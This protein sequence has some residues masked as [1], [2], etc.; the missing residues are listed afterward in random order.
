MKIYL[1]G[2]GTGNLNHLTLEAVKTLNNVDLILIP[3][4]SSDTIDLLNIRL[5][6]CKTLITHSKYNITEFQI[7]IRDNKKEYSLSVKQWH[8]EIAATWKKTIVSYKGKK[9]KVGLLIWGDPSLYDSS[10][11]IAEKIIDTHNITVIPGITSIQALMAAHK[12]NMNKIGK[13]FFVTTG[14]FLK[15][16]GLFFDKDRSFVMLD[17]NCSFQYINTEI[18]YMWW[19]AY[20]GMKKEIIYKGY[21][22]EIY[23]KVISKSKMA[24]LKYGWIMD[25]Y[26]LQKKIN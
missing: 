19:G 5:E 24:K 11:K 6:I 7:P 2:I 8:T 21:L 23:E 22:N 15:Q 13:P 1:I 4:K 3:K 26:L 18:Y 20:L 25:T 10:I 9:D 12:I 17:G 16:K 14:R